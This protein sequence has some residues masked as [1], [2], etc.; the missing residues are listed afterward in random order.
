MDR[1]PLDLYG[2]AVAHWN[3]A[4]HREPRR[5]EGPRLQPGVR[6]PRLAVPPHGG[7]DRQ[8]RHAVH[9]R[10]RDDGA[11]PAGVRDRPG[12]PSGDLD[13]A[14][15]GRSVARGP[16]AGPDGARRAARVDP[17]HRGRAG[18]RPGSPVAALG[19]RRAGTRRGA[20][21]RRGLGADA[22]AN[23]VA[24]RR[25]R[26][27]AAA[28]RRRRARRGQGVSGLGRRRSL[29]VPRLPRVR[30]GPRQRRIGAESG[31]RL[32]PGD[33]PGLARDAVYEAQPEGASRWRRCRTCLS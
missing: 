19:E 1:S 24:D 16:R 25:V 26:R 29:H 3:L 18:D 28:G 32:R 22:R 30:P 8:R 4:Q 20:S 6:A 12:D 9:R 15:R 10:L 27:P 11:R 23:A 14:R 17:P 2:A 7:R 31:R 13:P 33:S 5:G 21:R